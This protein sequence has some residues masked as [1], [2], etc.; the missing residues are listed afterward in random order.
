M[1]DVSVSVRRPNKLAGT[2]VSADV[3]RRI[4]FDGAK[5][6]VLDVKRKLYAIEATEPVPETID[7]LMSM[8]EKELGMPLPVSEFIAID[9]HEA[10]RR[11][12]KIGKYVGE[13]T[14]NGKKCHHLAL[15]EYILDWDLWVGVD[16]QLPVKF[17]IV[18]T[19]IEGKPKIEVDF[20]EFDLQPN[21]PDK[22]FRFTPP[23]GAREI[24][25]LSRDEVEQE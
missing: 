12:A 3:E 9:P 21:L 23:D 25:M 8:L 15:K 6:V 20:V 13:E 24:Q 18:A 14:L 22:L 16:S 5:F 11:D 2:V 19:K 10:M 1:A 17:V 4:Y 7:E